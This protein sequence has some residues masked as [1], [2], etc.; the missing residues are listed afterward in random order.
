MSEEFVADVSGIGVLT[1]PNRRS[2]YLY[3]VAQ[4][5][6]VSREQV[7]EGVDLPLHS[8][9]FHL[10]RLADEGLLDVEFRR[11]SDRTGPGAGRPS[12]LYRRS[13]RQLEISLP[14]R[15]YDLAGD[16]LAEAIERSMNQDIAVSQAVHDAA[17]AKG[18]RL[19][20]S[21]ATDGTDLER[22]AAALDRHGY[23]PRVSAEEIIL[24]NCPFDSLAREHTELVCDLNL[25]LI[26]GV[27]EGLGCSALEAVL[28]PQPG[29]CCVRARPRR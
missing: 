17:M 26:D 27:L 7:A 13:A 4:P 23:E 24:S 15:H 14:E 29:L 21:V 6:A 5:E 18:R 3:V 8:V 25:A 2:L 20:G 9:K 12:K 1:E 11:L 10:D 19:A 22:T 28:Q 16:V